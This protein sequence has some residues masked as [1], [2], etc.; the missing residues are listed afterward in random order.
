MSKLENPL[1]SNPS[2]TLQESTSLLLEWS[3]PFLWPGQQIDYF[4]V[5]LANRSDDN[6]TH[7]RVDATFS[8]EVVSLTFDFGNQGAS[9]CSELILE[10]SAVF[11]LANLPGYNVSLQYQPCKCIN[12]FGYRRNSKSNYLS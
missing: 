5:S 11:G 10:I 1:V 6:V 2:L 7:H 3:P 4:N 12:N 8:D 9:L